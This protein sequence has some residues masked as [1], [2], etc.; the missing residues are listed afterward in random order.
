MIV[1]CNQDFGIIS[2]RN[3]E[4]DIGAFNSNAEDAQ[5]LASKTYKLQQE[6]LVATAGVDTGN[7]QKMMEWSI[8]TDGFSHAQ[9][10][11]VS[12]P[13]DSEVART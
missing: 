5:I 11:T 7:G 13:T 2:G 3:G 12:G 8:H 10:M 9:L 6:S 1:C 4:P